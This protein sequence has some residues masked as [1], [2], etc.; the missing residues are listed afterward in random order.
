MASLPST[1]LEGE[2]ALTLECLPDDLLRVCARG[3]FTSSPLSIREV[4]SFGSCN[5]RLYALV[6][7]GGM[8]QEL[9]VDFMSP[10]VFSNTEG[11]RGYHI[12]TV[13]HY[14]D[15]CR[16][17]RP[18]NHHA[19]LVC[20]NQASL[21]W[22][23]SWP[24]RRGPL[25]DAVCVDLS[26]MGY[27]DVEPTLPEA[28]RRLRD[29]LSPTHAE[30][31]CSLTLPPDEDAAALELWFG[32]EQLSWLGRCARLEYMRIDCSE[33][34]SSTYY[35]GGGEGIADGGLFSA[36]TPLTQIRELCMSSLKMGFK[37]PATA[38][39]LTALS[40]LTALTLPL[41]KWDTPLGALPPALQSP[42]LEFL[43]AVRAFN[44]QLNRYKSPPA[45]PIIVPVSLACPGLRD[46]L[47]PADGSLRLLSISLH[48]KDARESSLRGNCFYLP[49]AFRF[50]LT[51]DSIPCAFPAL[52][53]FSLHA[54]H[55]GAEARYHTADLLPLLEAAP[56]LRRVH[57][58]KLGNVS[59]ETMQWLA[60][61][62][63]GFQLTEAADSE[64]GKVIE[65]P[66]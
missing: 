2:P 15:L 50:N 49:C 66:R 40:F 24:L 44:L 14:L 18:S 25:L 4:L 34:Y 63:P 53:E 48:A 55:T 45:Q 36:L 29:L 21:D 20:A 3:G 47:G 38:A 60:R 58:K 30:L 5:K 37:D 31:H 6:Q 19:I 54:E 59:L 22:L 42:S 61:R 11:D 7:G 27:V 35:E 56:G 28:W 23:C 1:P 16:S 10:V 43:P 46:S 41:A 26:H 12:Q 39:P 64:G 9:R 32:D 8:L 51:T 33:C 62:R 17:L 65:I 52:E 57:L 13:G